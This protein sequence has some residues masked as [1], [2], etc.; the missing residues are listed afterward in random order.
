[1]G[2]ECSMYG[3]TEMHT[4]FLLENI[5]GREHSK[6]PGVDMRLICEWILQKKG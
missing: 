3:R 5:K 1:M 6:G 4:R 2:M